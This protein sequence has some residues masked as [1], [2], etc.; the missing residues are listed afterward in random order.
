MDLHILHFEQIMSTGFRKSQ[1][2]SVDYDSEYTERS[3]PN[4]WHG[5]AENY[6]Q[7]GQ[8]YSHIDTITVTCDKSGI[9]VDAYGESDAS[10]KW[11]LGC[12]CSN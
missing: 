2:A 8:T 10:V 6:F 11:A 12:C 3:V 5:P 4:N 9:S 1:S 7:D